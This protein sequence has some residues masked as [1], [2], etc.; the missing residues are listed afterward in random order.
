MHFNRMVAGLEEL[1]NSLEKQVEERTR[2]LKASNEIAKV[3]SSILDPEELLSK[4]INLFTD[5]FNYYY[6][7]IYL[8]D[9]S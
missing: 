4:V 6:A 9:P 7:S 5:Q 1:Q 8:I 2:L 3:S